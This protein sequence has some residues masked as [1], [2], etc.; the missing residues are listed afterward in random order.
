LVPG[1]APLPDE[2]SIDLDTVI[3]VGE[4]AYDRLTA[5]LIG[6]WAQDP[7]AFKG[8]WSVARCPVP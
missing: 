2:E 4:D 1:G 5:Y 8:A 7:V 6:D 3:L